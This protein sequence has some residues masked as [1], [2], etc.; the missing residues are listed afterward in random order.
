MKRYILTGTP[1]CGKTTIIKA[2]EEQGYLVVHEAATNVIAM[3]QT[4]GNAEPWM[5]PAFIDEIIK[6]QCERQILAPTADAPAQFY[7]RSPVCTYALAV[8]LGYEPSTALLEEIERTAGIYEN[9]VFFLENL[10]F[11]EPTAA[12]RITFEEA[13]KFEK[14]HEEAYAKFGYEC[15][16]IQAMPLPNRVQIILE[17]IQDKRLN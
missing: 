12:R 4:K 11:C 9:K 10:G 1:G 17:A 2:L 3:E 5:S 8:Y 7:D 6:I 16:E 13:L 15:V 14:I